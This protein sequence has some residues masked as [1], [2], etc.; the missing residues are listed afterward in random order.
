MAKT[1]AVEKA[2]KEALKALGGT[3][4]TAAII[5]GQLNNL[6]EI[7]V[8]RRLVKQRNNQVAEAK[9][10]LKDA[11]GLLKG[12]QVELEDLIDDSEQGRLPFKS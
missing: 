2:A 12:A 5:K 8:A 10:V 1:K 9:E 7:R 3:Q 4:E 6:D 11:K